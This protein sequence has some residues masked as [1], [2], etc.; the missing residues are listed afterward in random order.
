MGLLI[1]ALIVACIWAANMKKNDPER[2][3]KLMEE[4]RKRRKVM[5]DGALK[6]GGAACKAGWQA[7]KN[8]K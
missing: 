4:D 3:E 2:Y 7:F 6:V 1:I 8:Q 5:L